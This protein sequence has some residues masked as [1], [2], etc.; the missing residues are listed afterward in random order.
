MGSLGQGRTMWGEE[1]LFREKTVLGSGL[2][3]H[4]V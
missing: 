1:G 2:G 3:E 4:V